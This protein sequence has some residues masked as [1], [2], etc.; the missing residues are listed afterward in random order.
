MARTAVLSL[1]IQGKVLLDGEGRYEREV[2]MYHCDSRADA[3]GAGRRQAQRASRSAV[4][5]PARRRY[6]ARQNVHQRGFARAV[7]AKQGVN[8]SGLHIQIHTVQSYVTGPNRLVR[9]RAFHD[10]ERVFFVS[11]VVSV[12]SH[13]PFS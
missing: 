13:A 8:L 6:Q 12:D 4:I 1:R 9:C 5:S 10:Q 2:L 3:R 11:R 7:L